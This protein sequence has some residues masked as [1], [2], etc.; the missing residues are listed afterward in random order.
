MT[1]NS[2]VNTLTDFINEDCDQVSVRGAMRAI[3]EEFYTDVSNV[4]DIAS[5]FSR[6]KHL[7]AFSYTYANTT[8]GILGTTLLL[9][10]ANIKSYLTNSTRMN[11]AYGFRATICFRLQVIATPFH[12][13]RLKLAYDPNYGTTEIYRANSLTAI[14]QL[15]GVELDLAETTSVVLRIP[16]I[17]PN[18]FFSVAPVTGFTD[19]L[20][21]VIVYAMTPVGLAPGI[22]APRTSLWM[23]LEDFELVGAAT[24]DLTAQSG[25]FKRK[26]VGSKEAQVVPGNLS[27]VLSAGSN[28]STWLGRRIP[29][30]SSV[31]GVASWALRHASNIASSYGWS[32]PLVAVMPQKVITSTNIFQHNVDGAD[33]AFSLGATTDNC[34]VPYVGFAGT[35]IDEM[36]FDYLTG[37][38]AALCLTQLSTVNTV[39]QVLYSCSLS[40][41]SMYYSG[42]NKNRGNTG[43]LATGLAIWP[44]PLFSLGNMFNQWRGGF[45]FTVKIAKTKFHT[46]RLI[47]GFNPY[48]PNS[49]NQIQTPTNTT[50][51]QFKSVIWDLRE[52][53]VIEFDCPYIAPTA[54]LEHDI[55]F[56][57]FFISVLEPLVAPDT[58][59]ST[60]PFIVEVSGLPGF[61]FA[62]P[63]TARM[64]LAPLDTNFVAQAGT[65][66]PTAVDDHYM[67]SMQCIG[68]RINSAKQLML[69]AVPIAVVNTGG[70]AIVDNKMVY[71]TYIPSKVAP[72]SLAGIRNDYITHF[73]SMYRF[74]RGGFCV[75]VIPVR[76][77]VTLSTMPFLDSLSVDML[78][79]VSEPRTALHVKMPYYD[80]RSRTTT[81]TSIFTENRALFVYAKNDTDTDVP[82]A[83]VYK[84]A[85]DDFQLGFFVGTSPLIRPLRPVSV[86]TDIVKNALK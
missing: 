47:L 23:W 18:N 43:L 81:S 32:K 25:T 28:L 61:E 15:P 82:A 70:D 77:D 26:D 44:T 16:F 45:R 49:S 41:S 73:A 5:Y 42:N 86:N 83:V 59:S 22:L 74:K 4:S 1:N 38:S 6:P 11:G 58:V 71:P 10:N 34:V 55:S 29:T 51:M 69:K 36:A 72:T 53:N 85:A 7:P 31:T 12:S 80:I 79:I 76:T 57:T 56:G 40:P 21:Q 3:P 46:G 17:H 52:G 64:L 19:Y 62:V 8:H 27:N 39:N 35:D 63:D 78:P 14:T 67:A 20:G 66:Q 48:F 50:D 33:S 13:G 9:T 60:V 24:A 2:E 68:E 84:R 54:Y 75:D 65:F 37:I 30:I